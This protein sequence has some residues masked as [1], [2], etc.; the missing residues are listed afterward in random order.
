LPQAESWTKGGEEA[1]GQY[2]KKV[3]EENRENG[4]NKAKVKD[5]IGQSTNG[6]SRYDHVSR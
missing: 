2:A 3:D 5:W 6:K 1:D 4:I